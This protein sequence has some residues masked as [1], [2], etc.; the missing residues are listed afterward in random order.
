[1]KKSSAYRALILILLVATL[2]A[3]VILSIA[4]V[5]NLDTCPTIVGIPV[6]FVLL[7]IVILIIISHL[8]F[9]NDKNTL[10]FAGCGISFLIALFLSGLQVVG[11]DQC[12]KL[13][14]T[15]PLCYLSSLNFGLLIEF[16]SAEII[17]R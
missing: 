15:I 8:G 1:M 9:I 11:W 17:K 2:A 7:V 14:N 5:K 13:L 16:K 6:C 10:F 12:P 4:H 3:L